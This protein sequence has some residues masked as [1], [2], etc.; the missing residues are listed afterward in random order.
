MVRRPAQVVAP[1]PSCL[2]PDESTPRDQPALSDPA[3]P[4]PLGSE[5][6]R[7]CEPRLSFRAWSSMPGRERGRRRRVGDPPAGAPRSRGPSPSSQPP[8][9]HRGTATGT[10]PGADVRGPGRTTAHAPRSPVRCRAPKR[11][12][13][14]P[15]S[16]LLRD[17]RSA[18]RIIRST[19]QRPKSCEHVLQHISCAIA[20]RHMSNVSGPTDSLRPA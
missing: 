12:D 15:R 11:V 19:I 6:T 2:A 3:A 20:V 7:V 4:R 16:S 9:A 18:S 8:R 13:R 10:C 14:Q 5:H 1:T 17:L